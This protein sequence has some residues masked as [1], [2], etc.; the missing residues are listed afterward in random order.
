MYVNEDQ[1]SVLKSINREGFS[2]LTYIY[3]L[4]KGPETTEDTIHLVGCL[5][6]SLLIVT[7]R[8]AL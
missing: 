4:D 5:F 8:A 2:L 6:L 3:K 1:A 7:Q